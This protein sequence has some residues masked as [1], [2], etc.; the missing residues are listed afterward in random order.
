MRMHREN[1]CNRRAHKNASTKM[2]NI[3]TNHTCMNNTHKRTP[4]TF[5][6]CTLTGSAVVK[7]PPPAATRS[8]ASVR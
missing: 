3:Y 6:S 4:S 2:D 8:A 1:K 5:S 7:T